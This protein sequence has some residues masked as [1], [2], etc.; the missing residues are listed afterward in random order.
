MDA[1][2]RTATRFGVARIPWRLTCLLGCVVLLSGCHSLGRHSE[3]SGVA[4]CA[5][6]HEMA[7][8]VLPEYRI[9][10]P[11][12]LE[13][14]ALHVIPRPPY[15]LHALD[16]LV[17]Q[18]AG[19]LPQ[20]PIDGAFTIEPGGT[21]YL[22]EP[23]GYVQVGGLT[24]PQARE[25]LINHLSAFL[26]SPQVN[27]ALGEIA[28]K[29]GIAGPH[30]VG[31]DGNVTLGAYGSVRV[32]GMTTAEAKSAVEQHLA[33]FLDQPEVAVD[34]FAYNSKTYYVITQG[35]GLGDGV[36]KFP[37]T[38]NDTVLDAI[39]NI[40]GLLPHSST[41]VW[42]AR[43]TEDGQVMTMPVDWAGITQ[44]GLAVTNYQV[45]PGDRI[46]VAEDSLV[47]LDTKLAKLLTPIE[48]IFAVTI[49][50]TRAVS[51]ITFFRFGGLNS[52][53]GF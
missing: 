32:L 34:V 33:Q 26:R 5:A 37:V 30:L 19:S 24:L 47:A 1:T 35:A 42:I 45:M 43:P 46:Y 4:P 52:G 16:S 39:S 11:D 22:G 17:I 15:Q 28:A 50:G 27:V 12:V 9:E 14:T 31:P 13:I 36:W 53:F 10:P 40:N 21:L 6:P 8:A 3:A 41:R 48:R 38:G 20:A 7:M 2:T 23:Y 44:A 49:L 51:D 18:V 29:Q 25:A